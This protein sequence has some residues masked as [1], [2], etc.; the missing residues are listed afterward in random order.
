MHHSIAS[1][2]LASGRI[3]FRPAGNILARSIMSSFELCAVAESKI[4]TKCSL[5]GDSI[6]MTKK[7]VVAQ[8]GLTKEQLELIERFQTDYNAVD[9]FFRKNLGADKLA[10]FTSLVNQ[11][12]RKHPGWRDAHVLKMVAEVRNLIV[13]CRTEPYGYGALP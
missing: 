12:E 13:H 6:G 11:Y 4:R 9:Q 2:A 5:E 3:T 7:S 1:A 8:V 10:T